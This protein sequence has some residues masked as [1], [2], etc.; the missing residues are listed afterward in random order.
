MTYAYKVVQVVN[1]CDELMKKLSKYAKEKYIAYGFSIY[2]IIKIGIPKKAKIVIPSEQ[3]SSEVTKCRCNL[4]KFVKVEKIYFAAIQREGYEYLRTRRVD[5]YNITNYIKKEYN[6]NQLT[7]ISTYD[8]EF[9][10]PFNEYVKPKYVFDA[11]QFISCA[12]GIHFFET[13]DETKHYFIN[14]TLLYSA[15]SDNIKERKNNGI[16]SEDRN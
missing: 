8:P 11:S 7:Y 3:L 15:F 16:F 14:N 10:Y 2:A 13:I 4:A 9:I 5:I 12:S 1:I 6:I